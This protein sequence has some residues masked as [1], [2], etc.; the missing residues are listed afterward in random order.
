MYYLLVTILVLQDTVVQA[1]QVIG[2]K[3]TVLQGDT[4]VLPCRL[5][6]STE[7]LT[8]ISFQRRTRL[9]KVNTNFCTIST[10]NGLHCFNGQ[11]N[12][13]FSFVGNIS[14]KNGSLQ[15]SNVTLSDEGTYT[16]IFTLFPSGNYKTEIP[17]NVLVPPKA[18]MKEN[19]LF[20]G[21]EEV[22]LGSCA[23]ARSWP[24][25]NVEWNL[26]NLSDILQKKNSTENADFTTTTI[27][28]LSGAPKRSLHNRLVQCVITS[29]ASPGGIMLPLTIQ[30][31]FPPSEVHFNESS[32]NSFECTSD[33]HPKANITWSR[34]AHPWP[35]SAVKVNGAVLQILRPTPQ[36]NGLFVCNATNTYGRTQGHL[37]LHFS[38]EGACTAGWVMFCLL[39]F[40]IAVVA[41]IW[42]YRSDKKCALPWV[43]TG[44]SAR[45]VPASEQQGPELRSLRSMEQ[46]SESEIES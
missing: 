2:G 39:L 24:P 40:I 25:A 33:A 3:V 6:E 14:L 28:T 15:L 41:A 10:N 27:N 17:L 26:G 29:P 22:V 11:D 8:Q 5:I 38:S 31:H 1:V 34:P 19:L 46:E 30:I 9:I 32:K 45:A 37:Y 43:T 21:N 4:A 20:E 16:C 12:E 35:D 18:S 13:R 23:A 36:L 42:F 7:S 44:D